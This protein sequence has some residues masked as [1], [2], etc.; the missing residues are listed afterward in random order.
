[1]DSITVPGAQFGV[2]KV[3]KCI[4]LVQKLDQSSK[5]NQTLGMDFSSSKRFSAP[6]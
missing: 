3:R 6:P 4:E 2:C 5:L 1:M